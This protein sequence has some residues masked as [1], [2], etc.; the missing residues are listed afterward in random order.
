MIKAQN[1][2]YELGKVSFKMD[3]NAHVDLSDEEFI[4]YRTGFIPTEE[5][6]LITKFKRK[7]RLTKDFYFIRSP[8]PVDLGINN[9]FLH[10]SYSKYFKEKN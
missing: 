2:L 1:K 10:S 8:N 7:N 9:F 4:K 3:L 6:T 5:P